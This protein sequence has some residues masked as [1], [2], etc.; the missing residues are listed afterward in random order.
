MEFLLREIPDVRI[1]TAD[2]SARPIS[3]WYSQK[4][5]LITFA[6]SRCPGVCNPYLLQIRDRVLLQGTN[7]SNFQMMV[8]S[9]DPNDDSK[10]LSK[11][12]GFT[13]AS[14]PPANWTFGVLEQESSDRLL[15]SLGLELQVVD[16]LY[17]HNTILALIDTNGKILQWIEGLPT[18]DQW[19]RLFKE[20]THDF[21]P[22]YST[23]GSNVW[24]SCFR[25]DPASGNWRMNWGLLLIVAPA[26]FTVSLL[27]LLQIISGK[28][29]KKHS[30]S[31]L[32]QNQQ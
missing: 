5:V 31:T 20:L 24:M 11:L 13:E 25:F 32:T 14:P 21:V 27:L 15:T 16:N 4:P 17:E 30:Y 2:S 7:E 26:I 28:A 23:L 12:A 29:R 1:L 10:R 9:F 3:R 18:N 22:V 6:Y 8:L 19:N